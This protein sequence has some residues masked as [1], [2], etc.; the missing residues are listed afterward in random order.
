MY[1]VLNIAAFIVLVVMVAWAMRHP[2]PPRGEEDPYRVTRRRILTILGP[3]M[4]ILYAASAV[5]MLNR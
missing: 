5:L 4:I 3:V 2:K 1:V